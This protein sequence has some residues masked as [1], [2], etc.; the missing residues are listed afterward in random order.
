MVISKE[1]PKCIHI[2]HMVMTWENRNFFS[3][4]GK[5]FGDWNRQEQNFHA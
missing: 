4:S 2:E 1:L 3:P 5:A